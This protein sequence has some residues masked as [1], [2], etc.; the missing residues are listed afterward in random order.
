MGEKGINN[1]QTVIY[2]EGSVLHFI[3]FLRFKGL[4]NIEQLK[5]NVAFCL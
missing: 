1:F 5:P 2:E 3:Y 4:L